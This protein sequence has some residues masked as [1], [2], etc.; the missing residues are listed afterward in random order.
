MKKAAEIAK[1]SN[2]IRVNYGSVIVKDNHII[3]Q[4]FNRSISDPCSELGYCIR[5]KNGIEHGT[6]Y[7]IGDC[8]HS[9]MD[10]VMSC[11]R[12][13]I[14]CKGATLYLNGIPCLLCARHIVISG[15]ERVVAM[16]PKDI[17]VYPS[18]NGIQLLKDSGVIVALLSKEGLKEQL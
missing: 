16:V 13:G 5:E 6:R 17:T 12:E 4:G 18:L 9:E 7:E 3:S 11:A 1:K 8:L 14:S 10:A 2:C 15:I